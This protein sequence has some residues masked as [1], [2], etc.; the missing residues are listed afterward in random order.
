MIYPYLCV[1]CNNTF[2]VV[3]HHSLSSSKE[4]CPKCSGETKYV[5]TVPQIN[6]QQCQEYAEFNP[7]LGCVVNNRAH[8]KEITKQ[9]GLIEIGNEPVEKIHQKSAETK[10]KNMRYYDA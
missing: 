4:S 2:E 1:K 9:M 5:Y 6:T 10:E 7:A 3:K 8:K